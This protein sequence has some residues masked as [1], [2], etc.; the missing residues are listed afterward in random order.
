MA[1][2]PKRENFITVKTVLPIRP[3]MPAAERAVITTARLAIRPLVEGDVDAYFAMR[4][5]PEVMHYTMKGQPDK[6]ISQSQ[7]ALNKFLPPKDVG[8]FQFGICLR[9]T[10]ELIGTGGCQTVAGN[11]GW[12]E[13]GYT[14]RREHWGKGLATEFLTAFLQTWV[15]LPREE[16]ELQVDPRTV[17]ADNQGVVP[18]QLI[19]AAESAN[20]RSQRVLEKNGFQYFATWSDIDTRYDDGTRIVMPTFRI[21]PG[22]E[23]V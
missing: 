16:I 12:P 6:D 8:I 11:W 19:A 4:S 15:Q 7:A 20:T 22:K 21:F 9:E 13:V 5:Q 1:E 18:E 23:T 14:L 10:G 17:P 3:F 2:F